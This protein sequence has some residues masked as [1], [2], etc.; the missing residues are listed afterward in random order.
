M[1]LKRMLLVFFCAAFCLALAPIGADAL[2]SGASNP[3]AP[4]YLASTELN[5]YLKQGESLRVT[6]DYRSAD[7]NYGGDSLPGSGT[8]EQVKVLGPDG[9]T[10]YDTGAVTYWDHQDFSYAYTTPPAPSD[11][12]YRVSI[13]ELQPVKLY[14]GANRTIDVLSGGRVVPGRIWAD[15]LGITQNGNYIMPHDVLFNATLY[16]A[17]AS[18]YIYKVGLNGYNGACSTLR[19]TLKD[20]AVAQKFFFEMPSQDLPKDIL[21]DP[22]G[23]DGYLGKVTGFADNEPLGGQRAGRILYML[24]PGYVGGFAI[25]VDCDGDGAYGGEADRRFP[26]QAKGDCGSEGAPLS[27]DFDGVDGLGAPIPLAQALS[28]RMSFES[29]SGIIVSLGDVEVLSGGCSVQQMNGSGAGNDLVSWYATPDDPGV[30]KDAYGNA[31][32]TLPADTYAAPWSTSAPVHSGSGAGGWVLTPIAGILTSK[33]NARTVHFR[34]DTAL[35]PDAMAKAVESSEFAAPGLKADWKYE[36]ILVSVGGEETIMDEGG[37]ND[38]I[39][40]EVAIEP[41]LY[42]GFDENPQHEGTLTEAAISADGGTLLKRYYEQR[43]L[44]VEFA[45]GFGKMLRHEDVPYGGGATAPAEPKVPGY[46]FA[47]WDRTFDYV[48]QNLLVTA[49]WT[50]VPAS[51]AAEEPAAPAPHSS[52][53]T[54]DE[55]WPGLYLLALLA[56]AGIAVA[57]GLKWRIEH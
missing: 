51:P 10:L 44:N 53:K 48:T 31:V 5:A 21:P 37:G 39:G 8:G 30:A 40:T 13:R 34:Q 54:G 35:S 2:T 25:E 47:G 41:K 56:A 29:A 9:G 22:I 17:S 23:E 1:K 7:I 33:G 38:F 16:C 11:G 45:D 50:P 36:Y 15:S 52:P 49:K 4:R 55:E 42:D 46:I 26:L 24:C 19:F 6:G 14:F 43:L 3:N 32:G 28:M 27:L 12:V 20:S 18:G 57:V